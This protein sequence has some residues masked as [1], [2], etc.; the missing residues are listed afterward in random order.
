MVQ[1]YFTHWDIVRDC[2]CCKE[3]GFQCGQVIPMRHRFTNYNYVHKIFHLEKWRKRILL[4]SFSMIWSSIVA[5]DFTRYNKSILSMLQDTIN[6]YKSRFRGRLVFRTIMACR[7]FLVS[8][9]YVGI[10]LLLIHLCG[11]HA[12]WNICT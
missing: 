11:M 5:K 9:P 12:L 2:I 4:F 3:I 1:F 10:F 7:F 6:L 8:H